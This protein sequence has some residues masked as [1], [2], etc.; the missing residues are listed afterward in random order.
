MRFQ[1]LNDARQCD[2]KIVR[3]FRVV[4]L[5]PDEVKQREARPHD[6]PTFQR[7]SLLMAVAR[8]RDPAPLGNDWHPD[9]VQRV[10][11]EEV[12]I[13]AL[14]AQ[15]SRFKPTRKYITT[16]VPIGEKNDVRRR[17]RS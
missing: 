9:R 12:R 15:A 2:D 17:L 1:E 6:D 14:D 3:Q 10:F 5:R 4:R 7:H 13:V 16:K 11:F 8:K